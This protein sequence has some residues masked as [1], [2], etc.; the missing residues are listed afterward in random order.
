M[1]VAAGVQD[2]FAEE[3]AGGGVDHADVE[4]LDDEDDA[5]SCVGSADA[6]V[7]QPA[8]V[9]QGD[10]PGLVDGVVPDPVVGVG[11]SGRAGQGLGHRVVEGG[12]GRAVR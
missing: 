5:G 12:R 4:V 7:V 3:L 2:Q 9:S 8:V 6:D 10:G 11:I 1:V